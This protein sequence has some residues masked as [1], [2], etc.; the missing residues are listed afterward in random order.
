MKALAFLSLFVVF[1]NVSA[2]PAAPLIQAAGMLA[3]SYQ[4]CFSHADC[5]VLPAGNRACGGPSYYLVASKLNPNFNEVVY[6]ANQSV[7]KETQFNKDNGT[8]SICSIL[9]S[10]V[11]SCYNNFCVRH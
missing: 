3:D 8:I 11:T 2:N 9:P 7:A 5:T 1:S 4:R 6:L 10:P